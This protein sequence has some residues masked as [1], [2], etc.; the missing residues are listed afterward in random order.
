MWDLCPLLNTL[1]LHPK[2]NPMDKGRQWTAYSGPNNEQLDFLNQLHLS[3][4][5][6]ASARRE[7]VREAIMLVRR[8]HI[9]RTR[10]PPIYPPPLNKRWGLISTIQQ[11]CRLWRK[12]LARSNR[13]S[14]K[15]CDRWWTA[16]STARSSVTPLPLGHYRVSHFILKCSLYGPESRT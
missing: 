5:S 9:L 13:R 8:S 16:Y 3:R 2:T 14:G 11:G 15:A 6:P 12:N 1:L 4:S 10:Y 7:T